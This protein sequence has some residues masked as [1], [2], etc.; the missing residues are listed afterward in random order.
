MVRT[1]GRVFTT[2]NA[3]VGVTVNTTFFV[4]FAIFEGGLTS[5]LLNVANGVVFT[6]CPRH[7][8]KCGG[9]LVRPITVCFVILNLFLNVVVGCGRAVVHSAFGVISILVAY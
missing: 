8:R 2:C 5:L 6:G 9:D 1:V 7:E 4:L 3:C